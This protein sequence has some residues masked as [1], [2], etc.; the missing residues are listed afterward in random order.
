[1][2]PPVLYD[3][4]GVR[5]ISHYDPFIH[6][7]PISL[8]G[9]QVF[10]DSKFQVSRFFFFFIYLGFRYEGLPTLVNDSWMTLSP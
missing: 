9:D 5:L 3:G 10:Y 1:M 7:F 8:Y 6:P 4:G 2:M